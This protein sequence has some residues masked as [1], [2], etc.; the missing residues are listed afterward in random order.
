MQANGFRAFVLQRARTRHDNQFQIGMEFHRAIHFLNRIAMKKG[1]PASFLTL[2]LV[3]CVASAQP[4]AL[5]EIEGRIHGV[6]PESHFEVLNNNCLKC[7]DSVEE[8]GGMN[9]EDISFTMDSICLLYTSPSP[10]D[11]G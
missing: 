8:E 7:H 10:R 2:G 1:R 5:S 3:T 6:M 9:L 4:L 11:R